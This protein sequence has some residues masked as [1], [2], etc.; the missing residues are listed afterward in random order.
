MGAMAIGLAVSFAAGIVTALSPC[1]LP[2]LPLVVGSAASGRRY[3]PVVLAAGMTCAFAI[4]GVALAAGGSVA[5]LDETGIR[6]LASML[7][8]TAGAFL[9]SERLQDAMSRWA[10]PLASTASKLSVKLGDGLGGQFA[11]G[12]LLGAIW[13]PCVGPTLGAALG[14]ASA[15]GGSIVAAAALMFAFGAGSSLPLLATAYASRHMLKSR[16]LLIGA[17]TRGKLVLGVVLL[18]VGGLTLLG[19]DRQI[20]AGL[21]SHLPQWWIDALARA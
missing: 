16:R 15:A 1:V 8:L 6:R 3:G 21:L 20:E 18:C 13:S 11:I 9:L 2:V 10:S 19:L 12:A 14:L 17:G 4:V 5:G 7:L